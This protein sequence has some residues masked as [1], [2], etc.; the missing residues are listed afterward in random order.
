MGL[1]GSLMRQVS[2]HPRKLCSPDQARGPRR[3]S[4]RVGRLHHPPFAQPASRAIEILPQSESRLRSCRSAIQAAK[5]HELRS[6]TFQ[7]QRDD[8][9]WPHPCGQ[10]ELFH[11]GEVRFCWP[12]GIG[13]SH[14][15]PNSIRCPHNHGHWHL[16]HAKWSW[17]IAK[18]C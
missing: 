15:A 10:A 1:A 14:Q 12:L 9:L 4:F 7:G 6:D 5:L 18:A 16:L 11:F 2:H 8:S 13:A 3:N 17:R